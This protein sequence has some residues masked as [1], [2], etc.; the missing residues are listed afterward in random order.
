MSQVKVEGC[1]RRLLLR[2]QSPAP[3]IYCSRTD[4]HKYCRHFCYTEAGSI[5]AAGRVN[6]MWQECISNHIIARLHQSS[7]MCMAPHMCAAPTA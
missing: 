6:N 5:A 4:P 1:M 2:H 3:C 7:F